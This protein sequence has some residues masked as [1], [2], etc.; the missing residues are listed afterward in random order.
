MLISSIFGI[1]F[2]FLA[3]RF[4]GSTDPICIVN[5]PGMCV[6]HV[7]VSIGYI[8][9]QIGVLEKVVPPL[10]IKVLSPRR[11]RSP[12]QVTVTIVVTGNVAVVSKIARAGN[13]VHDSDF[14]SQ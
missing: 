12:G 8:P 4:V 2:K 1:N 10:Q 13:P 5:L 6:P 9:E 14:K 11:V 3:V 7:P